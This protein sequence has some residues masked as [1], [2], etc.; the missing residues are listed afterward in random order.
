MRELRFFAAALG[1]LTRLPVYRLLQTSPDD[2]RE[3]TRYF[4]LVGI[5][6]GGVAFISYWMVANV[7]PPDMAMIASMVVSI[8]LTGALHEDGLADAADGLGGG[9][10]KA[11]TLTIMQDSRIGTYG[12][13]ALGLMLF[14]K[15]EALVNMPLALLAMVLIAAH[16]VSRLAMVLV[17]YRQQYVRDDGKAS[18]VAGGL[19]SNALIV[20]GIFGLL[21]LVALPWQVAIS[22][23]MASLLA[24]GWFARK[25]QK[26]LGGYTGDCLGAMQQLTELAFYI[27][28]LV[29]VGY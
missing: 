18:A 24:G 28:I 1:F 26:R 16:T 27:G 4:P 22:G 11:Q 10:S 29:W 9:W 15:F 6:V 20:A 21:P 14:A 23:L 3:A 2:L 12:V 13:I 25:L 8:Y 19:G 17:I 7:L 5:V